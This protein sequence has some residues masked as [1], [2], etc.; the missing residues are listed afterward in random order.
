MFWFTWF[1]F[2]YEE[3]L[4]AATKSYGYHPGDANPPH[5]LGII[6]HDLGNDSKA[7]EYLEKSL[8]LNP[9]RSRAKELLDKIKS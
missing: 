6:Y 5:L 8:E 3:A 9:K 2:R 4:D 1:N 7:V